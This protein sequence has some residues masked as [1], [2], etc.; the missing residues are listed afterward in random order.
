MILLGQSTLIMKPV[1]STNVPSSRV[2][3]FST[4]SMLHCRATQLDLREYEGFRFERSIMFSTTID[5]AH[6]PT[7]GE[8]YG[9]R[10][11][12]ATLEAPDFVA[13]DS[14]LVCQSFEE[15]P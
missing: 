10:E 1:G 2:E 4:H 7:P 15:L 11:S 12:L 8:V 14:K 9:E 3:R 13:A 5:L 6:R